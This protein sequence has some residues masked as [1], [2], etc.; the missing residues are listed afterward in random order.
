MNPKQLAGLVG[1][2]FVAALEDDGD[3]RGELRTGNSA[4]IETAVTNISTASAKLASDTAALT[5]SLPPAAPTP[6]T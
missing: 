6:S 5:A 4:A 2:L 3:V 1:F